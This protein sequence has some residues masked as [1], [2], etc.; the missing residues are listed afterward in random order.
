MILKNFELNSS[1][2]KLKPFQDKKKREFLMGFEA[3]EYQMEPL[4]CICGA[5]EGEL[6]ID[7][8]RYGFPLNTRLCKQ[9]GALRS[10]PYYD[11][12]SLSEFYKTLYGELYRGL[13][14]E[15]INEQYFKSMQKNLNGGEPIYKFCKDHLAGQSKVFEIGCAAGFNIDVFRQHG[16]DVYGCDYGVDYVNYGKSRGLNLHVGSFE[17]L[18]KFGKADLIIINHVLEHIA[19]PVSY[20]KQIKVKLLKDGGILYVGVP[21]LLYSGMHYETILHLFQNAHSHTY[22]LNTLTYMMSLSGFK[23]VKGNEYIYSLFSAENTEPLKPDP[24]EYETVKHFLEYCDQH[25]LPKVLKTKKKL[26]RLKII[27]LVLFFLAVLF[28]FV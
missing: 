2:V 1:T 7:F 24:H 18:K 15:Q 19:D 12:P 17:V 13:K 6:V 25:R 3:G 28:L 27:S 26:K 16:H 22:T 11:E 23:F 21:G 8:D 10:D 14:K 5:T 4:P 20:I 9:C